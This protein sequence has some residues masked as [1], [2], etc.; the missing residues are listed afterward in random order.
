MTNHHFS[1]PSTGARQRPHGPLHGGTGGRTRTDRRRRSGCAA[2]TPDSGQGGRPSGGLR[3]QDGGDV[4]TRAGRRA[5]TV[6]DRCG[7]S[8]DGKRGRKGDARPGAEDTARVRSTRMG[9]AL[10]GMAGVGTAGIMPRHGRRHDATRR[11]QL[12]AQTA[13]T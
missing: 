1:A 11:A 7:G 10:A 12:H 2:R 5:G 8:G 6:D 3:A 9:W 13:R 4:V